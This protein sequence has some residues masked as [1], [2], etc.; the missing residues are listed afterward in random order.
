M[1]LFKQHYTRPIPPDAEIVTKNGE[2]FARFRQTGGRIVL[3]PLLSDGCRCRVE[4]RKWYGQ[5]RD[6]TGTIQRVP[7]LTDKAASQ[8]MLNELIR[9]SE[10]EQA[11]LRPSFAKHHECPI[12]VHL[13]DFESHL[14]AKGNVGRGT[15]MTKNRIQAIFEGC[16][17]RRIG[18]ISASAVMTWLAEQRKEEKMGISTAN[19]YLIAIKSFTNWLVKNQ[20][21]DHDPLAHLSRMNAETDIRRERR[22]ESPV[23]FAKLLKAARNSSEVYRGLNG[24]DREILYL[25]AGYTGLRA[26]ELGSLT[27]ASFD[28]NAAPPRVTVEAGYSKRKRLDL[29]P[30]PTHLT[31]TIRH[32]LEARRSIDPKGRLWPGTWWQRAAEMLREDLK[33]AKIPYIDASERVFDFHALRHQFISMLA[34]AG[35]HPKIAQQLARHSDINLTM[36][37]YTHLELS[38][39]AGSLELMAA[40]PAIPDPNEQN[41]G[42]QETRQSVSVLTHPLTQTSDSGCPEV[43]TNGQAALSESSESTRPNSGKSKELDHDC[44]EVSEDDANRAG[45]TRTHNQQIMSLLAGIAK[46]LSED[47]LHKKQISAYTS[48]YT[49]QNPCHL[50]S[51]DVL[52]VLAF[53]LST[54]VAAWPSLSFEIRSAVTAII[55]SASPITKKERISG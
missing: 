14:A 6:A 7:L 32:W 12:S 11:G 44:P 18:D 23:Q 2:R 24:A 49:N 1:K 17:F 35:V 19:G 5:Y 41:Q 55:Q 38:E 4:S 15:R 10:R 52:Q 28:L 8:T 39:I 25:I 27:P 42:M 51:P 33:A 13:D 9:N 34:L 22:V 31:E 40:L 30:L 48:T 43:T 47:T 54:V 53:E 37:C 20:R 50:L 16:E 26:S 21:T 36:N 45:G 29:Q 3:A 46:A